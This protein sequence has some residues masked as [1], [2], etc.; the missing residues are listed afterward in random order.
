VEERFEDFSLKDG[1]V[2][3]FPTRG[4][5]MWARFEIIN[6]C[7]ELS[8]VSRN[9][10]SRRKTINAIL[11]GFLS[12]TTRRDISA[13]TRA[14]IRRSIDNLSIERSSSANRLNFQQSEDSRNKVPF[15][16]FVDSTPPNRDT[17]IKLVTPETIA[18]I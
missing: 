7:R 15:V 14:F 13:F 1:R 2:N 5:E 16:R 3:Y 12:A 8:D 6:P 18:P 11:D 4:S 10:A 17:W 9:L